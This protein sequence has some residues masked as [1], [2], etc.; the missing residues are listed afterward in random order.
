MLINKIALPSEQLGQTYLMNL[1][2][3]VFSMIILGI[4]NLDIE[5]FDSDISL[6]TLLR[7]LFDRYLPLLVTKESNSNQSF[8]IADSVLSSFKK[9]KPTF[10]RSL[11]KVLSNHFII[12][13]KENTTHKHCH[14][15]CIYM[16]SFINKNNKANENSV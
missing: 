7:D 3:R 9:A 16:K 2:R 13:P 6:Q 5:N 10:S 4:E 15:V 14:L 12:I 11:L 8:V 1:T